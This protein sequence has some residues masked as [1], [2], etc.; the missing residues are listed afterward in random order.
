VPDFLFHSN[1]RSP[2]VSNFTEIHPVKTMLMHVHRQTN[3]EAKGWTDMMKPTGAFH[4][5]ANMSEN[6]YIHPSMT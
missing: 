3:R 2:P 1:H 5:Y 4:N 6:A